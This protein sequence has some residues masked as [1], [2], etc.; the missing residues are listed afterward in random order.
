LPSTLPDTDDV[1]LCIP[2]CALAG[3][4]GGVFIGGMV[5]GGA[6]FIAVASGT[7]P[8]VG[9]GLLVI[10]CAP[11]CIDAIVAMDDCEFD[12]V[13]LPGR[14]ENVGAGDGCDGG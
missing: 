4:C 2:P 13:G 14:I 12:R 5:N 1:A 3:V 8:R 7:W 9:V 6:V 10:D 11:V